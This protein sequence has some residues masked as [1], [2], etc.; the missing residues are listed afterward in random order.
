MNRGSLILKWDITYNCFL[1]C[2]H[3][4][5]SDTVKSSKEY[6]QNFTDLS[7]EKIISILEK[8]AEGPV[9]AINFLGGEP[10]IRKDMP[11]TIR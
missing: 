10:F 6:K 11:A 7:F 5:N 4:Y 1:R 9:T 3:C 2:L 8:C